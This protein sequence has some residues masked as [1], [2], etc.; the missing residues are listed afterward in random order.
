MKCI[1]LQ[2]VLGRFHW[3]WKEFLLFPTAIPQRFSFFLFITADGKQQKSLQNKAAMAFCH[4][5]V[6]DTNSLFDIFFIQTM[7][8]PY[9]RIYL[10]DILFAPLSDVTSR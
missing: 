6:V 10:R 1:L 5:T 7:T 9:L 8:K 3:T 4:S 2:F